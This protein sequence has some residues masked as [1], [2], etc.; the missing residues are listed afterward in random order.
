ML[1]DLED[2]TAVSSNE[3][4][5]FNEQL[6]H[7]FPGLNSHCCCTGRE[8]GFVERLYEGTYFS[9]VV[10]HLALELQCLLGYEVYFGKTRVVKEPSL[11]AII[12]EYCN[13]CSCLEFGRA[14]VEIISNLAHGRR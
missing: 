10:E 4:A 11:Y 7:H 5:G 9:H 2:L 13:D 3:I 6:L 8:G 14:A 12:Y 1:V